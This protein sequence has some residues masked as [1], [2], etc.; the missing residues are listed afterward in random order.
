MKTEKNSSLQKKAARN[1]T[2]NLSKMFVPSFLGSF[3][4]YIPNQGNKTSAHQGLHWEWPLQVHAVVH[5]YLLAASSTVNM[6][7]SVNWEDSSIFPAKAQKSV[8]QAG[9]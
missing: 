1:A 3:D 4:T 9:V 6:C 5:L 8:V 2:C 7:D